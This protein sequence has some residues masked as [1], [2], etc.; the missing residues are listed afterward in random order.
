MTV[1]D[2]S[3]VPVEIGKRYR[4]LGLFTVNFEISFVQEDVLSLSTNDENPDLIISDVLGYY[5]THAQYTK[6]TEVIEDL[7]LEGGIWLT[8]ELIEPHGSPDPRQ[9]TVLEI[10]QEN[11][12]SGLN[13]FIH[14]VWGIELPIEDI[15][16]F[17][18]IRWIMYETHPRSSRDE[19][20][21][22]L[23]KGLRVASSMATST[24]GLINSEKPRIFE[25]AV[26]EKCQIG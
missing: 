22:N 8:R 15:Q 18:S 2:I 26:I 23:P 17:E 9:L 16:N 10:G 5:L 6:L 20:F 19:Y 3:A 4:N 25:V 1:V 24:I 13:K 12:I 7:L 14:R 11:R 21:A